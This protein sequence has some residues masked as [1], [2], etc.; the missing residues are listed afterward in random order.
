MTF[1]VRVFVLLLFLIFIGIQFYRPSKNVQYQSTLDDFLLFEKAPENVVTIIK[2]SCYDCH[3]NYTTYNWYHNIAPISWWVDRHAE[4]GKKGL[5]LSYWAIKDI[6]DKRSM[7]AAIA[8]DITEEKMP[9]NSYL[10]LHPNK[11]LSKEDEKL[12]MDW[13][14]TIELK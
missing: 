6:R 4:N 14:Y 2:K 8:F 13:L 10:L 9:L 1:R 3:S 5:N 11:K 12:I 7:L